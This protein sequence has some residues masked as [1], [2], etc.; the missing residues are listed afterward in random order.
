MASTDPRQLADNS[1]SHWVPIQRCWVTCPGS[2]GSGL[3]GQD[4]AHPQSPTSG[5]P[6]GPGFFSGDIKHLATI[7]VPCLR[8]RS[9]WEYLCLLR[10]VR[11][12]MFGRYDPSVGLQWGPGWASVSPH[13]LPAPRTAGRAEL[14]AWW[15]ET[16]PFVAVRKLGV[17]GKGVSVWV[18]LLKIQQWRL[19]T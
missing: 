19:I 16:S 14:G 8:G 11:W 12:V 3:P 6:H 10:E 4:L 2:R 17:D 1:F 9:G 15:V 5:Q 13:L 18:W 7:D